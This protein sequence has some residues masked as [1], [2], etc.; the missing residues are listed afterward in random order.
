MNEA[1]VLTGVYE[2]SIMPNV[3]FRRCLHVRKSEENAIGAYLCVFVCVS[4]S[5]HFLRIVFRILE[6]DRGKA[7]RQ[8]VL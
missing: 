1:L 5:F 7:F 6:M 4:L 3:L 2:A 8:C